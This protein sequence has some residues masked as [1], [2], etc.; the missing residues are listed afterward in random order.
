MKF[1]II[2]QVILMF[3]NKKLKIWLL[4]FSLF[5]SP[6]KFCFEEDHE[7]QDK[8]VPVCLALVVHDVECLCHVTVA[9]ITEDVVNAV[10]V[11][12]GSV[13]HAH[14]PTGGTA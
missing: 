1:M 8:H 6:D 3:K 10:T 13:S 4:K 14:V 7:A 11:D 5:F 9:V 12:L 2:L